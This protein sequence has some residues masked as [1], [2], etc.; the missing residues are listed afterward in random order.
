MKR[1]GLF[2]LLIIVICMYGCNHINNANVTDTT[3]DNTNNNAIVSE[4]NAIS[5]IKNLLAEQYDSSLVCE[6]DHISTIEET[7]YYCIH[8][9]CTGTQPVDT[10]TGDVYMTFT[11]GWYYVDKHTGE[12]YIENI[13]K[14]VDQVL[15]PYQK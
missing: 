12:V 15:V 10:E 1:I 13:D 9:Y 4:A 11:V 6:L 8:A 7:E 14:N 3:V 5:I 2:A